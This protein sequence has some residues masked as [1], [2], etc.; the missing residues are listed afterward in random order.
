[1]KLS[2]VGCGLIGGERI[3]SVLSLMNKHPHIRIDNIYDPSKEAT[4]K[5]KE[6][7]VASSLDALFE[8]NP[9]WVFI[10]TPHN[11]V[12]PIVRQAYSYGCNVLI[13]KPLGRDLR[14]AQEIVKLKPENKKLKVGFNYRFYP[15]VQRLISDVRCNKFGKLISIAMT[16][17]H[18]NAPGMETSWKLQKENCGGG[19]LIDH[20][21]HLL[22]LV[23]LIAS[24]SMEVVGSKN[25]A[26]FWNTGIEEESHILLCDQ[27]GTIF[28]I[29]ISLNRWRSDFHIQVN[30]TEGYGIVSGRGRSYGP[31]SY[32]IGRRWGWYG[33]QL[34]QRQSEIT[35]L[36]NDFCKNSF[37]HEIEDIL[38]LK[39]EENL[40]N[41]NFP[42]A[43]DYADALK[44]MRLLDEI[45]DSAYVNR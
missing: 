38:E 11:V 19:S 28:N 25:W 33:G 39:L 2:I 1:M 34:D 37:T 27:L 12:L 16:L 44:T 29:E 26:G 32:R 23:G 35:M 17:G 7:N 13:E 21:I 5:Y 14:E 31:Q 3:N 9:D 15:G 20:G 8:R 40:S 43:C 24:G 36:E 30:G 6:I 41:S 18:G 22:D 42:H 10:C 45:R 4:N